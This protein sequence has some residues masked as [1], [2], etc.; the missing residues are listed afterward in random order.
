MN[1]ETLYERHQFTSWPSQLKKT[2]FF[3]LYLSKLLHTERYP[4]SMHHALMHSFMHSWSWFLIMQESCLSEGA[5]KRFVS[6]TKRCLPHCVHVRKPLANMFL[7]SHPVS[8]KLHM[9]ALRKHQS[10]ITA[11]LSERRNISEPCPNRKQWR[12]ILKSYV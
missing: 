9:S 6:W 12:Y 11:E 5:L 1:Y 8:G 3:F 7:S 2:P 10:C 4:K